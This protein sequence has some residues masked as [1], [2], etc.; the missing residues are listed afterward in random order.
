MPNGLAISPWISVLM[1]K[2][3][4]MDKSRHFFFFSLFGIHI[5][6]RI[7][8]I[9]RKCTALWIKEQN[10]YWGKA[11]NMSRFYALLPLHSDYNQSLS[12]LRWCRK[13][14]PRLLLFLN[15]LKWNLKK[16]ISHIDC[17][18]YMLACLPSGNIPRFFLES[19]PSLGLIWYAAV[20]P[21]LDF[22]IVAL[23]KESVLGI[24]T[25]PIQSNKTL[26]YNKR[27]SFF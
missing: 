9:A 26:S 11:I 14:R 20:L 22:G 23:G 15:L 17:G 25:W 12:L 24:G 6:L 2:R 8:F 3:C 19:H 18:G 16:I 7:Y 10:P 5:C 4:G 13:S 27:S 21:P 1:R